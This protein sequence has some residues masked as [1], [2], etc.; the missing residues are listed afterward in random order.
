[1]GGDNA[2]LYRGQKGRFEGEGGKMSS[3][4][5]HR[6][7][8]YGNSRVGQAGQGS[9]MQKAGTLGKLVEKGHGE[10]GMAVSCALN[11]HLQ[12]TLKRGTGEPVVHP[13]MMGA[14]IFHCV[15]TLFLTPITGS[16]AEEAIQPLR[17]VSS[18]I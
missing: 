17:P 1:M 7:A 16:M 12:Q 13:D 8:G 14:G 5:Q 15:L 2:F 6:F 11:L 18:V 4:G 10:D 3:G 9:A